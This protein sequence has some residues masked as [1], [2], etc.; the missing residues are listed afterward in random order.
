V[1]V[2][3][4]DAELSACQRIAAGT[5]AMTVYKPIKTLAD[6]A[7]ELAIK[8]AKKEPLGDVKRTVNNG[9]K[10]VPSVLLDPVVVDK[11][12]LASTVV[13]DGFHKLDDV[14]KD[15]PKDQWPAKK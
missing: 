1:L 12:N 14:Y 9:K 6:K 8:M 7:A 5:Q 10:D 15:I 4:Q 11:D 13:A 3:G 2:S